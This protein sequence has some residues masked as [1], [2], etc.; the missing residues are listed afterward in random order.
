MKLQVHG[1]SYVLIHENKTIA[2]AHPE[3]FNSDDTIGKL[4]IKNCDAIARGYDLDKFVLEE[5]PY[6]FDC[7]LFETLGITE[8]VQKSILIGMLQGTLSKGFNK[9]LELLGDKK[10]TDGQL[11]YAHLMGMRKEMSFNQLHDSLQ[12][13]EWNVKIKMEP[14]HDGKFIDDGKTH[15]VD[16]KWRPELDEDGCIILRKI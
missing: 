10:Y 6:D 15:P 2:F 1:H 7:P 13:I 4:S 11:K 8:R 16:I 3:D 14:Y 12:Q 5:F 9:A